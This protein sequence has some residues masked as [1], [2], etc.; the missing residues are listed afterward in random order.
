MPFLLYLVSKIEYSLKNMQ[1][2]SILKKEFV[3]NVLT[4]ITGLSIS[5]LI[6]YLGIL[7]LTRLFSEEAFGS[8]LL[9]SSLIIIIKPLFSL[10]YELSIMLPKRNKDP[11]KDKMSPSQQ[12][13]AISKHNVSFSKQNMSLPKDN[14][15]CFC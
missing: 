7:I 2:F 15:F 12:S 5:Q 11:P 14:L 10:Q 1:L 8:Y 6:L 9:F 3:K 4:L 13:M